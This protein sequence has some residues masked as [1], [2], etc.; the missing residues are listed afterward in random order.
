MMLLQAKQ[1]SAAEADLGSSLELSITLP[2]IEIGAALSWYQLSPV[3]QIPFTYIPSIAT[4]ESHGPPFLQQK[5]RE[6]GII[7]T[8][9]GLGL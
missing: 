9:A 8:M 1:Y 6:G 2:Q 4:P 7:A 5:R 3:P